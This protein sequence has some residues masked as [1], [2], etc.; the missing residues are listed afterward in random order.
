MSLLFY[1]CE[2]GHDEVRWA[3]TGGPYCWMCGRAGTRAT[4]WVITAIDDFIRD[5]DETENA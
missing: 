3:W 4:A 1:R 2:H 5:L